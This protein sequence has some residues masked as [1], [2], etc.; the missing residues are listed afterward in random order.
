MKILKEKVGKRVERKWK[1][2]QEEKK[3]SRISECTE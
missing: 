1:R 3:S 2:Q